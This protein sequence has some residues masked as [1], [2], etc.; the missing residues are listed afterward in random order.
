MY[1]GPSCEYAAL[2]T[3]LEEQLEDSLLLDEEPDE[4][5]EE[6]AAGFEARTNMYPFAVAVIDMG[7]ND[8][9]KLVDET[10]GALGALV[11]DTGFTEPPVSAISEGQLAPS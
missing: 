5:D 1:G 9:V 2:H 11:L 10:V 3:A 8:A 6:A 7:L 4:D